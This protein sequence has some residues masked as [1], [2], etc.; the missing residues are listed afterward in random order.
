MQTTKRVA[1]GRDMFSTI[2]DGNFYYVDKTRFLRPV[3]YSDSQV[4]LFTRPRRFGKTLTMNMIHEFLNL[5]PEN[6]GDTSRQER[7]F[8]GL[9]VMKD[10]EIVHEYMGQYP[11]VFMTLKSVSGES[12]EEAVEA[13]AVLISEA[14]SGF[15]YLK[16]SPKLSDYEKSQ[17]ELYINHGRLLEKNNRY[18]IKYF[19]NFICKALYKHFG[20]Q[21]ILLIDEYDVPLAKAQSKGYHSEMV[22]LYSQ[23]L[24]ILKSSG[25]IGDIVNK[26][27]MTGCL[28]VAKN[29]IFTGANN[30]IANTVLSKNPEFASF[31][32]FTAD[33]TEKF[34][35]EFDLSGYA[36][37]VKENY[38]GYRFYDKE[39]YCPW[40]VCSFISEARRLKSE[41]D[42]KDIT[43]ANYWIGSENTSTAAIK[44]YVGFLSE[45][46]NQKLQDL[47]DG[48][49]I[50]ITVNDSMNYDSLSLHNVNDMWSLLLHT[51]YLTAVENL[52]DGNYKVK[53]PNLEIKKCFDDSI[54]ASFLDALTADNRNYDILKALSDGDN[55]KAQELIGSLLVPYISL[56]VYANKSRPENFYE[57]F[58]TGILASL[59]G[60][61]TDFQVEQ[62]V[63]DGYADLK[64]SYDNYMS[65]MVIELKVSKDPN[66]MDLEAN[67]AIEQIERKGYA[68]SFITRPNV[69]KVSAVAIVF[70]GKSCFVRNKRLK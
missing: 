40:D 59:D 65:G 30:F 70:S 48:K 15:E 37:L 39:M 49:D 28:K 6:P 51:G 41:G 57:G 5:N 9:D 45:N 10:P 62:E 38:D 19:L 46:D 56:R 34:L 21:V 55:L 17:L 58:M 23:F 69:Y 2:I 1:V 22:G 4:L 11:V 35:D 54:Q 31:M 44:S 67:K 26:I 36:D 68:S 52:G 66:H 42:P 14:A 7:L 47:Y 16:Q 3:L 24:D 27:V 13:L 63:G 53:I 33:E 12:F 60:I 25:G 8:K 29:S 18:N 64:F 50:T 32:G 20:R 61:I 43:A